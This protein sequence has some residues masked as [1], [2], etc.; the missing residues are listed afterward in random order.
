MEQ[1][2]TRQRAHSETDAELNTQLEQAAAGCTQQHHDPEHGH[3]T[4]HQVGQGSKHVSCRDEAFP[5]LIL[6][7]FQMKL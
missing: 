1:R 7:V 3:Q 2:V 5:S 6:L 4:D